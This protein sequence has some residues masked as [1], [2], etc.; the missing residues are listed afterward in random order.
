MTIHSVRGNVIFQ[1]SQA[2]KLAGQVLREEVVLEEERDNS[3][4]FSTRRVPE[5]KRPPVCRKGGRCPVVST[6]TKHCPGCRFQVCLRCLEWYS[7][8]HQQTLGG[9]G[10]DEYVHMLIMGCNS[11]N[12]FVFKTMRIPVKLDVNVN[13]FNE[14]FLTN[15]I[16]DQIRFRVIGQNFYPIL[17]SKQKF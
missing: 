7:H 15:I 17:T 3:D 6:V 11:H 12:Q 4:A 10:Y 1:Q 2:G 14:L 13:Y 8:R 9:D 16:W 5:R